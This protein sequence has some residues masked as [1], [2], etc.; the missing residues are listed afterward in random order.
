[1]A[2][3][4]AGQPLTLKWYPIVATVDGEER[5]SSSQSTDFWAKQSSPS[6]ATREFRTAIEGVKYSVVLASTNLSKLDGIEHGCKV[7]Y[8]EALR[9]VEQVSIDDIRGVAYI[10]LS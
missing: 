1:M 2:E 9:N 10:A 5:R 8:K 3:M 6:Q 7:L 4:R